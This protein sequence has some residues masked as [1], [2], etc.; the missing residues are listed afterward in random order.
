MIP[1]LSETD[2]ELEGYLANIQN[3]QIQIIGPEL[4][5]GTLYDRMGYSALDSVRCFAIWLSAACTIPAA[6]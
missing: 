1:G 4:I 2:S 6:N 3:S 5:F